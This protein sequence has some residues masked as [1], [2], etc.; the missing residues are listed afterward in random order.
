MRLVQL[1]ESGIN[2]CIHVYIQMTEVTFRGGEQMDTEVESMRNGCLGGG[3][4]LGMRL[5]VHVLLNHYCGTY[6]LYTYYNN[7]IQLVI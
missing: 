6:T 7:I 1:V 3:H 4:K 2:I 5:D